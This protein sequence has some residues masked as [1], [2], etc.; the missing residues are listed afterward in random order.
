MVGDSWMGTSR[1][2]T[3]HLLGPRCRKQWAILLYCGL[4]DVQHDR[5]LV[6]LFQ[7]RGFF[8]P[9]TAIDHSH[10]ASVQ[11]EHVTPASVLPVPPASSPSLDTSA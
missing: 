11:H 3:H 5:H 4:L 9:G 1:R 6:H 10:V 8:I 7:L 2:T